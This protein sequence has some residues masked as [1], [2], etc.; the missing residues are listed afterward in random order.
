M[1]EKLFSAREKRVHP[2]RDDKILTSW[3]GLMIAA[4]SYAGRVLNRSEYVVAAE[5]SARFI[6]DRM[7]RDDG[8]LLSRYR[9]GE[10][11]NP[12]LLDDY[13]FLAWGLI[14]AYTATFE[15]SSLE[16]A[17]RLT[18]R[19]IELFWDDEEGG[20]FLT[21]KDSEQLI[22]RPKDFY[23][24]AVPSGNSVA[25]MNMVKL[26]RITGNGKYEPF[27]EGLFRAASGIAGTSPYACT[28]LIDAYMNYLNPD[29]DI[30]IVGG[31]DEQ[32]TKEMLRA[33]N[34]SY[35]PFS[36]I[37]QSDGKTA[38]ERLPSLKGK[39]KINGK[40]TAYVCRNFSCGAPTD[41]PEEFKKMIVS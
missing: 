35:L 36:T 9:D 15:V 40:A 29:L 2:F 14:E 34:E 16:E 38:S 1:R 24:G 28:H 37:V 26:A 21:G 23:D 39:E 32:G 25:A 11:A 10:A 6:M 41:D 18:E 7:T 4:L 5:K 33:Y 3:N 20:F 27:I 31:L 17:V 12:G 8:R 19:M 30:A 13:A 22:L